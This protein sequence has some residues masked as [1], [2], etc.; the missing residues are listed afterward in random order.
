[1]KIWS[2]HLLFDKDVVH[3]GCLVGAEDTCELG[4]RLSRAGARRNS[5]ALVAKGVDG[6]RLDVGDVRPLRFVQACPQVHDVGKE[7]VHVDAVRQPVTVGEKLVDHR[8]T[9]SSVFFMLGNGGNG[10]E[11]GRQVFLHFTSGLD[12]NKVCQ[13]KERERVSHDYQ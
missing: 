7:D 2:G 4:E 3:V 13:K 9:V 12:K 5:F 11:L 10:R 1:M 6:L 8:G